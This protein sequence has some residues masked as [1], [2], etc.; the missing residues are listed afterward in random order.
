MEERRTIN[1]PL[2]LS[3]AFMCVS[4]AVRSYLLVSGHGAV[5][6]DDADES[7][8]KDP[9]IWDLDQLDPGSKT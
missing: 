8:R 6:I 5:F 9:G 1:A 3:T 7:E 4:L 2:R